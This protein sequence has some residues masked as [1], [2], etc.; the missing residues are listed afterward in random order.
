MLYAKTMPETDGCLTYY[1]EICYGKAK[2]VFFSKWRGCL[3]PF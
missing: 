1:G 3:F 2:L